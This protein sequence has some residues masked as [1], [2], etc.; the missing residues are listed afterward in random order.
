[1]LSEPRAY[2]IRVLR[3]LFVNLT[4]GRS[5]PLQVP[6]D[7]TLSDDQALGGF[8]TR[9]GGFLPLS[10]GTEIWVDPKMLV[11]AYLTPEITG[12]QQVGLRV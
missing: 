1:M 7:W 3:L 10:D 5:L 11:T 8:L 6:N 12:G 4:D 2:S 9:G